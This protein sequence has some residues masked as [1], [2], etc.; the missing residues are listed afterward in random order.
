MS[1]RSLICFVATAV[2]VTT[3][4]STDDASAQRHKPTWNYLTRFLGGGHSAGYHWRTPGPNVDYYNPYSRTNSTLRI[5]GVPQGAEPYAARFGFG[6][7]Q[8]CGSF[9]QPS[10]FGQYGQQQYDQHAGQFPT[11][12]APAAY[13]S[14][15]ID[16][17]IDDSEE[18]VDVD[19]VESSLDDPTSG[20]NES[21]SGSSTRN[22]PGSEAGGSGTRSNGGGG[23]GTRGAVDEASLWPGFFEFG[24][25]AQPQPRQ[26]IHGRAAAARPIRFSNSQ[27]PQRPIYN[28]R[29]P[30]NNQWYK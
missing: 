17:E 12:L 13:S 8:G 3:A 2:L 28:Q 7:Q 20:G 18:S 4:F 5:G 19:D 30:A 25:N 6:C 21:G 11:E 23:S 24:N 29:G 10:G 15:T 26:P 27:V 1:I 16:A 14:N 9:D 22:A